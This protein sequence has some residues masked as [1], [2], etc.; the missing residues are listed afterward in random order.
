[1]KAREFAAQYVL[2]TP[3]EADML[4]LFTGVSFRWEPR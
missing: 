4:E 2:Q 3:S 1:M